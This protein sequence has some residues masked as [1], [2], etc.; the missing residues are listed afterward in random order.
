MAKAKA[1]PVRKPAKKYHNYI[2]GK[3]VPSASN[4]WFDNVNPADSSD[5]IGRFPVSTAEDMT[6]AVEAAKGA[7]KRWRLTPAPHRAELLFRLGEILRRNK[8]EY[9][10][11][12]T[13]EM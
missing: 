12:M 11:Q 4:Q 10:R 1:A 8:D 6:N 2:G 5:V 9:T 13:R 3:W 7:A